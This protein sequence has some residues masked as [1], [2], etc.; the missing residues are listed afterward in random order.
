VIKTLLRSGRVTD[1]QALRRS[2]GRGP[3][4]QAV[5]PMGLS[6]VCDVLASETLRALRKAFR[7]AKSPHPRSAF[8]TEALPLCERSAANAGQN[9]RS[10]SASTRHTEQCRKLTC[11][12][13]LT[14][15]AHRGKANIPPQGRDFRFCEGLRMPAP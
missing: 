13:S 9:T 12:D 7:S 3:A 4:R 15:S 1:D 6:L 11:R 8:A 10:G 2:P 14:M 5:R